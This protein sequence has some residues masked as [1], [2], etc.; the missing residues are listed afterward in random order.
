MTYIGDT[1]EYPSVENYL[2]NSD[3]LKTMGKSLD[4]IVV[5]ISKY[6]YLF[7]NHT[8]HKTKDKALVQLVLDMF[9][10]MYESALPDYPEAMWSSDDFNV[11]VSNYLRARFIAAYNGTI[12]IPGYNDPVLTSSFSLVMEMIE[13]DINA[14]KALSDM[15]IDGYMINLVYEAVKH[16]HT[17]AVSSAKLIDILMLTP[18][19]IAGLCIDNPLN[20]NLIGADY[21]LVTTVL[22]IR[23]EW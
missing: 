21:S 17:T 15:F 7:Y 23:E 3:T 16:V 19:R 13:S 11:K 6:Y 18:I 22:P 9:I 10:Y 2:V 4:L 14:D 20:T 1:I 12:N 8:I 5:D